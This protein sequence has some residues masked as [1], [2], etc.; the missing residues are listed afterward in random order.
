MVNVMTQKV[1]TDD[2]VLKFD[3]QN[4]IQLHYTKEMFMT[5]SE[6]GISGLMH[7][8]HKTAHLKNM[9]VCDIV[10]PGVFDRI[11]PKTSFEHEDEYYDQFID[12]GPKEYRV[13][14]VV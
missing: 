14:S 8:A 9:G 3:V 4:L 11:R 5:M 13:Q 12:E 2:E 6:Q 10:F 7:V 1:L